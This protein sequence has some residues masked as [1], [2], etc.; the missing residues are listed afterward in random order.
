[1]RHTLIQVHQEKYYTKRKKKE[2]KKYIKQKILK[3]S[4][5]FIMAAFQIFPFLSDLFTKKF[6]SAWVIIFEEIL[7]N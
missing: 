1:V 3:K 7:T 4:I 5:L 6:H 2:E